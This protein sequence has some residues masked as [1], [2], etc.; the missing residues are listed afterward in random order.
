MYITHSIHFLLALLV[1]ICRFL[2]L[3]PAML[4]RYGTKLHTIT[5]FAHTVCTILPSNKT[6]LTVEQWP[7]KIIKPSGISKQMRQDI[8]PVL[9][10]HCVFIF[11]LAEVRLQQLLKEIE[12]REQQILRASE[13]L[14]QLEETVSQRRVR[15]SPLNKFLKHHL[16][17]S[18]RIFSL[19]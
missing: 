7:P 1:T 10:D 18:L 12:M 14:R 19:F 8:F 15:C 6:E 17:L 16:Q 3:L 2:F 5:L 13:E 9:W 11:F 4:L